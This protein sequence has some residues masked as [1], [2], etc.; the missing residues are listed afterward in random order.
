[1]TIYSVV[2]DWAL[3]WVTAVSMC[4][5]FVIR[6]L[7]FAAMKTFILQQVKCCHLYLLFFNCPLHWTLYI[8]SHTPSFITYVLLHLICTALPSC[9]ML[10]FQ[11]PSSYTH[12]CSKNHFISDG[13]TQQTPH[14]LSAWICSYNPS[15]ALWR[16]S[17]P[18]FCN[19]LR[20]FL[21]F[22]GNYWW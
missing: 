20:T 13:K 2:V 4:F 6:P 11:N 1:M 21:T 16:F 22:V 10:L 17:S 3:D 9:D 5:L 14:F 7:I 12:A 15:L 18:W 8:I 19:P